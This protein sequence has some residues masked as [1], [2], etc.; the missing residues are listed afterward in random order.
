MSKTTC[1]KCHGNK[2]V[3]C[4]YCDGEGGKTVTETCS[5]C[6]GSGWVTTSW[7]TIQC[8][9]C[10]GKGVIEYFKKCV[11]CGGNKIVDCPYCMGTGEV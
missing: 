6:S 3:Q 7:G 9:A 8:G 11:H 10:D 1:P 5:K 2:K 4:P